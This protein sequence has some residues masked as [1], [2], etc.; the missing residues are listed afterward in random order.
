[1]TTNENN[2]TIKPQTQLER[3]V[4]TVGRPRIYKEV[5][6]I[7][8]R[9]EGEFE[10]R[11]HTVRKNLGLTGPAFLKQLLELWEQHHPVSAH[12]ASIEVPDTDGSPY[13][14]PCLGCSQTFKYRGPGIFTCWACDVKTAQRLA[15]APT[16]SN[17]IHQSS[18]PPPTPSR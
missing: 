17:L 2:W 4:K 13:D 7:A 3:A 14:F 5:K 8:I 12:S 15:A 9:V 10:R 6:S 18:A 16:P 1:M 11:F